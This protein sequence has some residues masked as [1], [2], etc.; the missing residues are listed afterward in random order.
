MKVLVVEDESELLNSM[1]EYLRQE[2]YM[3]EP[4]PTYAFALE[5]IHLY[6]YD[7]YVFDLG[8]SDGN[9]LD[10]IQELKKIKPEAG[11]IIVSAQ[12]SLD[13]KIKGLQVGADDY[14]TK[15]FHLFEL[16]ARI[17]AIIRRSKALYSSEIVFNEIRM[18]PA[19]FQVFVENKEI[20]LTKKE[21]GLLLYFVTNKNKIISKESIAEHLWGDD[22]DNL[23][24]FNFIYTHFR[25]LRKKILDAGGNDY[26]QTVY[27]VGYKFSE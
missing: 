10:L 6:D 17:K 1:T 5:K 3:C 26:F 14:L 16:N 9:G 11:I 23:G 2:G 13:D 27:N 22:A 8:L 25:N 15:P 19:S 21:F 18:V 4:S 12:N 24:S 7:C 20:S